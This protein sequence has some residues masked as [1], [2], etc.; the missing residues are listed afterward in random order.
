[1]V[2]NTIPTAAGSVTSH[3]HRVIQP[4]ESS[5]LGERPAADPSP[6][7]TVD[8]VRLVRWDSWVDRV[9]REILAVFDRDPALAVDERETAPRAGDAVTARP[10]QNVQ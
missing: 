4:R 2:K 3:S 6:T 10:E 5:E 9:Y 1:M 7:A 8:G